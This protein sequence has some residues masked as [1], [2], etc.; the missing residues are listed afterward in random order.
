MTNKLDKYEV[1]IPERR[2]IVNG[3]EEVRKVLERYRIK[4]ICVKLIK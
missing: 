3:L 2:Y 4:G 1:I